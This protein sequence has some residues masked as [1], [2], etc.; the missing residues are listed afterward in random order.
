VEGLLSTEH[1]AKAASRLGF[2]HLPAYAK[3]IREQ[4]LLPYLETQLRISRE[5]NIPILKFFEGMP[6]S[7][8]IE[9]GK[10][11]NMEF[12]TLA[13]E[14]R[15]HDKIN[16]SLAAMN[17]LSGIKSENIRAEDICDATYILKKALTHFVPKYTGD[18]NE[19][20][21]LIDE[22][23]QYALAVDTASTD[24]YLNLLKET[25]NK[26]AQSER[27]IATR[28][29][30]S[31]QAL[32]KAQEISQTGNWA[33]CL[34]TNNIEWSDTLYNIYGIPIGTPL[35][36]DEIIAFTDVEYN[37][38]IKE[39]LKGILKTQQPAEAYFSITLKNG[40]KKILYTK[41][42][43]ATNEEGLAEKIVGI[44]QDVTQQQQL[45]EKLR[46]SEEQYREAQSISHIGNWAKDLETDR[47]TWS[48]EL[49]RIYGLEPQ[50]VD[51]STLS[52][53]YVHPEDKALVVVLQ[54]HLKEMQDPFDFFYRIVTDQGTVKYLL[55][56]G[57]VV[58]KNGK[59]VKVYGTLQDITK[60]KLYEQKLNDYKEFIEKITNVS[61]SLISTRNVHTGKYSYMN[62]AIEKLLG[63]PAS[64]VMEEGVPF[65]VPLIHPDDLPVILK[66]NAMALEAANKLPA[67]APEPITEIKYRIKNKAGQYR[68]LRTYGTIFERTEKGQVETMLN[69]S[70]DVTDQENVELELFK[71]NL[72][73]Q[74]SNKSLE[75][76]A[77]VTSHD[78]KEPLRKIATFSDRL[79][80]SQKDALNADGVL[81]LHKIINSAKRMQHM[82]N[83]L[84]KVST[85]TG[86]KAYE[87]YG[88][89]K[90]FE[91]ALQLLDHKIEECKAV[92]ECD[93][94]PEISVVPSQFRQLF[95]NLLSNSLK[96]AR[97]GVPPHIRVT[98]TYLTQKDVGHLNITKAR[99]YLQ[100][101]FED[102][103]I[104]FDNEYAAKIFAIFQR[105]HGKT[106]YE[107]TGIGLSVCEKVMENH[108]GL[109]YAKGVLNVGATFTIVLP[110][111]QGQ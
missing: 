70:V 90:L 43:A 17:H 39:G 109:I 74:Q 50:S 101:K 2:K 26:Q 79:L 61:P 95:Q 22:I 36:F 48:D 73:L 67:G 64:K 105:L 103:G 56:R 78:L 49:Y 80:S 9:M 59:A 21:A 52:R 28:L 37:T 54:E 60:Q 88:L 83:D 1:R 84:L 65:F 19:A 6:D 51:P 12:L 57:K 66:K 94:L 91:E 86:N 35:T 13:E 5:I 77:F 82:I 29:A 41:A 38:E 69:V 40:T 4:H 72:L 97:P 106:A 10:P 75:E 20:I 76:Y 30:H 53:K 15:L 11:V 104:G 58:M 32:Q 93:K 3:F 99:K 18:V 68:W 63:Y 87:Q 102:N 98:H 62:S 89:N 100:I 47:I 46:Y 92:V 71:K 16:E 24:A 55:S 96:F 42:E 31:E 23:D 33:W 8:I 7:A 27:E 108:A 45:V 25:I 81:L 14:N 111:Y 34:A 110:V 44:I 85:I 107:G